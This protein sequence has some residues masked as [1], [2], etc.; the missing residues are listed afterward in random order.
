MGN[1]AQ[2]PRLHLCVKQESYAE[3]VYTHKHY[4]YDSG[5]CRIPYGLMLLLVSA[6]KTPVD[7]ELMT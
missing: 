2:L 1:K 5:D 7:L 3:L 4:V 6:L